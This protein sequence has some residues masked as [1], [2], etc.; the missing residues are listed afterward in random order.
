MVYTPDFYVILG[1]SL[2]VTCSG[3]WLV[4]RLLVVWLVD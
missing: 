4:G 3:G 2:D 1:A